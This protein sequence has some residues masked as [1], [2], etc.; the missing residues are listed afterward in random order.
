[1]FRAEKAVLYNIVFVYLE[2]ARRP[3][4]QVTIYPW[5]TFIPHQLI[6]N[7]FPLADFPGTRSLLLLVLKVCQSIQEVLQNIL[8]I[9]L[10]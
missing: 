1:M 9:S 7:L 3:V 8:N 10:L 2:M 6:Q 5:D 4:Q